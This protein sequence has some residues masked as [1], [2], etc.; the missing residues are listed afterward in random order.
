MPL[1]G[2][3]FAIPLALPSEIGL[4]LKPTNPT[5]I[6]DPIARSCFF[7]DNTRGSGSGVV[8]AAR[9]NSIKVGDIRI[10][11]LGLTAG[12][13]I[14]KMLYN[15]SS[16]YCRIH[17]DQNTYIEDEINAIAIKDYSDWKAPCQFDPVNS[18]PYVLPNDITLVGMH[19]RAK[20]D[21]DEILI[22]LTLDPHEE[23][24]VAGYPEFPWKNLYCS[25][26]LKNEPK[27]E[28][29]L[30]L[31]RAFCNFDC[32]IVSQGTTKNLTFESNM[33]LAADYSSTLGVSGGPVYV[34]RGG[35][36]E[37]IGINLGGCC[38]LGQYEI[39]L[40]IY[41][42]NRWKWRSALKLLKKAK[43]YIKTSNF[44]NF[45]ELSEHFKAL[46]RKIIR[47][48]LSVPNDLTNLISML[49]LHFNT[50]FDLDHNVAL[51]FWHPIFQELRSIA[52][53]FRSMPSAKFSS[54]EEFYYELSK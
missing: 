24:Y 38:L 50:L 32:R 11:S 9:H 31:R 3:E 51:P 16:K 45:S 53:K 42:V 34:Q 14:G 20:S 21:I 13:L 44:Y 46:K 39:G 8:I 48:N 26:C 37:L 33:L 4:D 27:D 47:K 22:S 40:V 28:I 36:I 7:L 41:K 49:A 17:L 30:K 15:K 5:L 1:R 35:K 43:E 10:K 54:A 29:S 25:P 52:K 12:H 6:T 23:I 2:F 19:R 18:I